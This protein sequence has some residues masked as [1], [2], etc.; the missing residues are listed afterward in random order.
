[1]KRT[2]WLL[3]LGYTLTAG[4]GMA[5]ALEIQTACGE[6]DNATPAATKKQS[7]NIG[8]QDPDKDKS[9]GVGLDVFL[10]RNVAVC[11]SVSLLAS[12]PYPQAGQTGTSWGLGLSPAQL[13]GTVGF[14]VLF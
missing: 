11:S 7:A 2:I 9:Y 14:K 3:C 12:D 8:Q 5:G 1:M 6:Q 4:A 13:G 10:N